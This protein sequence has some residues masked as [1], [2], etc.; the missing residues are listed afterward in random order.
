MK[1]LPNSDQLREYYRTRMDHADTSRKVG[2]KNDA[3]QS[4]R[5]AQLAKVIDVAL[6]ESISIN[7]LGCGLGDFAGFLSSIG[8]RDCDYCGYDLLDAMVEGATELY[9]PTP[10]RR[11]VKIEVASDMRLADYTVASGIMN[12]KFGIPEHEWLNYVL[13][14]M[15]VMNAKSKRGFA[16]NALTKY[17]DKE[18][19]KD[20]LFYADPCVLFDYCKRKLSSNVALLHDY[21][22][23]DF[24]IIC[25]KD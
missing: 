12:L 3:A 23:Y 9:G 6:G 7:D 25:R 13:E 10:K 17:S 8:L 24:T 14:I 18:H 2:W 16:F 15:N 20:E 19:M 1:S 4:I 21:R 11:F 5:F 22:E